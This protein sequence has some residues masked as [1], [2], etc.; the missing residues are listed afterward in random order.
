MIFF[1]IPTKTK[2]FLG[3]VLEQK[4]PK[5]KNTQREQTCTQNGNLEYH[6]NVVICSISHYQHFLQIL[7]KSVDNFCE[8]FC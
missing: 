8:S 5:K 1:K 7:L 3:L 2:T 4:Q 6:Q